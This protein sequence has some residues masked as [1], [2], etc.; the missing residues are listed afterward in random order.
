MRLPFQV[1]QTRA[2]AKA[3]VLLIVAL[4]L[5]V[6][7]QGSNAAE[8]QSQPS[9]R[10]SLQQEGDSDSSSSNTNSTGSDIVNGID[11]AFNEFPFSVLFNTR[12]CGGVLIYEDVV[13]TAAH[14]VD[15][16]N[17]VGFP[18]SVRI[19]S[20]TLSNGV[21]RDVCG[22]N[23]HPSYRLSGLQ[24]DIAILQLCQSVN[25]QPATINDNDSYPADN[26]NVI[27]IGYGRT[28]TNAPASNRLQ[29]LTMAHI[30]NAECSSIFPDHNSGYN[31]CV[32]NTN[33]G[34][35]FADSGSGLVDTN[36]VLLGVAS[37][38]LGGGE[39]ANE[40][41]DF[42]TRASSYNIW[43]QNQICDYSSNPPDNCGTLGDDNGPDDNG[44][45]EDPGFF[46]RCI[47]FLFGCFGGN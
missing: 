14:C 43:L 27:A 8:Q 42:Y 40:F 13:A 3:Q 9:L 7:L 22:G 17:D 4:T 28:G 35:C 45:E 26:Q 30:G 6:L 44:E 10:R 41:P 12:S 25:L 24:N 1:Q 34:I 15:D 5:A 20:T 33:G 38:I 46:L 39:C 32:D 21:V 36:G 2:R 23:I 31:I 16:N 47:E 29:K 19:G 37:F 11:A 18:D